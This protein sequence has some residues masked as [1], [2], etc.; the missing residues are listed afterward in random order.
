MK[1]FQKIGAGVGKARPFKFEIKIKENNTNNYQICLPLCERV[2]N[3]WNAS[4][5]YNN[6]LK[7]NFTVDW[8]DGTQ[9]KVNTYNS[10]DRKHSYAKSRNI[11]Y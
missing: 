2:K 11:Y 3:P 8:G 4:F 1:K 6:K 5:L 10:E 9:T 7:Y